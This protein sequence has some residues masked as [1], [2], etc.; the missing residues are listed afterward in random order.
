MKRTYA[1]LLILLGLG[2]T[3]QAM[4]MKEFTRAYSATQNSWERREL[5]TKLD[6]KDKKVRKVVFAILSDP[7]FDWYMRQGAIDVL[8][9]CDDADVI[10]EME[11]TK[12]DSKPLLAEGFALAFG[13]SG[14]TDR[15]P[16]VIKCLKSKKDICRRA[17]AIALR[18]LPDKKGIT[19]LIEAWEEEDKFTVWVHYLETLEAL[20]HQKDMNTA[21]A[22][23]DWWAVNQDSFEFGKAKEQT[24]DDKSGAVIRT[25][26]KGTNLTMRS[27]GKGLPLLVLPDYGF[28]QDYLE[29]YLRNLEDTNQILYMRLPGTNDFVEPPLQKGSEDWPAQLPQPYYPLKR[30]G[31][32]FEALQQQ[33][34]KEGKI[35]GKFAILAHG[36]SCWIA[37]KFAEEH[38]K[39]VRRMILIGCSSGSK[40]AGEG[41][42]RIIKTGQQRGDLEMEHYGL[43][44]QFDGQ[45]YKYQATSEPENWA[46]DRK[47][48]TSRFGDQRNL[49]IGRL[50]GPLEG[51]IKSG[52]KEGERFK[53][54]K[55]RRPMGGCFIPDFSLFKLRKTP[56]PTMVMIGKGSI[57]A[58]VEDANQIA[59]FYG[60]FGR[61][62]VFP[63]SGEMPFIEENEK[64]VETVRKWL[65]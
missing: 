34:E 3:A 15:V 11:K 13:Q 5:I 43:S 49:E 1:A 53:V 12:P 27:R 31:D 2:A 17:A 35:S 48:F 19:A 46:L 20:T 23:K 14:K 32:A 30:I 61:V 54:A 16:Y 47:S 59:K 65:K 60:D 37:M 24:D 38:P 51:M 36:I 7:R 8:A 21:Q 39:S 56:T 6:P 26:V 40:A 45:K 44:R 10:S 64:F 57:E 52:S 18:N 50:Y 9:S 33:L 25:R 55:Y 58:S 63:R 62:F 28:E 4:D 29:T 22:Y 41:I 42:D